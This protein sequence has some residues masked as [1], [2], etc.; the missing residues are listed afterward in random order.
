MFLHWWRK[1]YLLAV[2]EE[3]MCVHA[4]YVLAYL[5]FASGGSTP[6]AIY[7]HADGGTYRGQWRGNKKQG[8]GVYG[9]PGGG[10]YE[11]MW[12]DNMKHG[13]G[14]YTFP[15]AC[16]CLQTN[17]TLKYL[18]PMLGLKPPVRMLHM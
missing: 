2:H 18:L 9:Y 1:L 14:V 4:V 7:E 11:G 13:Y 10:R 6:A 3:T 12:R 8:L 15:K 16:H 17:P 5:V